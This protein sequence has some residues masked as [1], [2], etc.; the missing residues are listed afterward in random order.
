M[1]KI[2]KY[3]VN[4]DFDMSFK[5]KTINYHFKNSVNFEFIYFFINE[6]NSTILSSKNQYSQ[7]YLDMLRSWGLLI[8]R[9]TND[10]SDAIP[11]W[12]NFED[13]EIK[14]K[15]I[16]KINCSK[17]FKSY[18]LIPDFVFTTDDNITIESLKDQNY[19]FRPEYS[20]SG[21][22]NKIIKKNE[23]SVMPNG[24]IA[25]YLDI[26]KTF[27]VTVNLDN[28]EYFIV[29]NFTN[30][31]GNFLGGN[32]VTDDQLAADLKVSREQ[33]SKE[34]ELIFRT[35]KEEGASGR[36]QFDSL[37]YRQNDEIYWYKVVE[38]NYRKTMGLFIKRCF[39]L[40]GEGRVIFQREPIESSP[41]AIELS[42]KSNKLKIYFQKD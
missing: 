3:F 8:P 6:E 20:F 18:R 26:Y 34:L 39:E 11:W 42:P 14:L 35:L 25:P 4:F 21:I 32:I 19:F 37:F 31:N 5:Q 27:G 23:I 36:V 17:I 22:G 33:F 24:V 1:E 12:G 38:V 30:S 13:Y 29:Q 28:F 7:D 9:I 2:K 15:F 40:F 41:N 16:S 10:L